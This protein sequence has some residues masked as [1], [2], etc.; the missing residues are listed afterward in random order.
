MG[1]A[2]DGDAGQALPLRHS[3]F[4]WDAVSVCVCVCVRVFGGGE[5]VSVWM[6]EWVSEWVYLGVQWP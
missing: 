4:S 5:W 2:R 3:S 1:T 6:D